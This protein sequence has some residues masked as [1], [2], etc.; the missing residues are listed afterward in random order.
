[1]ETFPRCDTDSEPV[2]LA[3]LAFE[4]ELDERS[5]P[6][7]SILWCRT[8]SQALSSCDASDS[9]GEHGTEHDEDETACCS[10]PVRHCA[11]DDGA[12]HDASTLS[13]PGSPETACPR[14]PR[15][16]GSAAE[17]D[18]EFMHA[19]SSAWAESRGSGSQPLYLWMCLGQRACDSKRRGRSI[20][21]HRCMFITVTIGP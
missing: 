2:G 8:P 4:M 16:S 15:S 10:K 14:A 12:M 17:D 18:A 9:G 5:P 13:S 6:H 20:G 21:A 11:M 3:G 7:C 19:A 1:M